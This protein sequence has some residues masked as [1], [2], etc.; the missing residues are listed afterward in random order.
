MVKEAENMQ[1][2]LAG[3]AVAVKVGS[4]KAVTTKRSAVTGRYVKVNVGDNT[5]RTTDGRI[6]AK[7]PAGTNV[8]V[9]FGVTKVPARVTDQRRGRVYVDIP[10]TGADESVQS[11][12]LPDEIE[13]VK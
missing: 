7:I 8:I 9:P 6:V 4:K 2:K 12:F 1:K 10:V 5:V 11:S 13:L 3:K